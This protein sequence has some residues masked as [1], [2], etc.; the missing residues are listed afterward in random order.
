MI[1]Q[2]KSSTIP[3]PHRSRWRTLPTAR[4][5]FVLPWDP[6]AL[7]HLLVREGLVPAELA[8]GGLEATQSLARDLFLLGLQD[9]MQCGDGP[10]CRRSPISSLARELLSLLGRRH[11]VPRP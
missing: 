11:D 5:A 10:A 3:A 8:V 7:K 6:S 4:G 9:E 1:H 2:R